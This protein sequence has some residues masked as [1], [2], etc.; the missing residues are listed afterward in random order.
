MPHASVHMPIN[1]ARY[2]GHRIQRAV[3]VAHHLGSLSGQLLSHEGCVAIMCSRFGFMV[4]AHMHLQA[5]CSFKD[6]LG[7]MYGA[8]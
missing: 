7:S 4:Q 1:P 2:L 5:M 3:S 8:L 6:W